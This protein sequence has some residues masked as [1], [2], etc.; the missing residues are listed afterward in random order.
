M[1]IAIISSTFPETKPGGVPTYVAGRTAYLKRKCEVRLFALGECASKSEEHV[2]L[3]SPEYFRKSFMLVWIRLVKSIMHY[4]PDWIEVHNIP[5]GLPLFIFWR[6]VYFFHGPAGMEAKAEGASALSVMFR[7]QLES[8]IVKRA[9]KLVVVSDAFG[10]LIQNIHP[11]IFNSGQVILRKRY[12]KVKLPPQMDMSIDQQ[13]NAISDQSLRLICV[14]RLVKRTGVFELVQAF[15]LARQSNLIDPN[16]QLNIVGDGPMLNSI[17]HLID[18]SGF[19]EHI[20][21]HGRLCEEQRNKLY[22]LSDFN[23]VPTQVLEGFGLVVVESALFGCPSLVTEIG[24]LPEVVKLL[25]NYGVI[26]K[27]DVLGIVEALSR[28]RKYKPEQRQMLKNVAIKKFSLPS[29]NENIF[30]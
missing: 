2:G 18:S 3:G 27:A 8:F 20:V 17:Q 15:I 1:R 6:P 23:I 9:S 12:P 29:R 30:R 11:E 5:L 19:G 7:H 4:K 24:G 10:E 16:S 26:C 14:R 28:L 22:S 25:D 13:Q 21:L